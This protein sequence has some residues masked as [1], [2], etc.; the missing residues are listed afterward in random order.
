[1]PTQLRGRFDRV[2]ERNAAEVDVLCAELL[3][4]FSVVDTFWAEMWVAVELG[5]TEVEREVLVVVETPHAMG[6]GGLEE[7]GCLDMTHEN[8]VLVEEA[9]DEGRVV[10]GGEEGELAEAEAVGGVSR[11]YWSRGEELTARR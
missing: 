6:T 1:M 11:W 5:G 3:K 9:E 4:N 10:W 8:D 2:N 7:V